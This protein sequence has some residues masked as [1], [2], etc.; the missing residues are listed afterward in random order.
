MLTSKESYVP[1]YKRISFGGFIC[2]YL[3]ITL[4]FLFTQWVFASTAGAGSEVSTAHVFIYFVAPLAL[5]LTY[6]TVNKLTQ[7]DYGIVTILL[8][9]LYAFYPFIF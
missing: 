4:I 7:K 2:W 1:F 3:Y 6:W 8:I 9:L 5:Q